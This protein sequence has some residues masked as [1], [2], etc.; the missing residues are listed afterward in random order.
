MLENGRRVVYAAAV[1]QRG[2]ALRAGDGAHLL[3]Q[4]GVPVGG[5]AGLLP[6]AHLFPGAHLHQRLC[7]PAGP[8]HPGGAGCRRPLLSQGDPGDPGGLRGLYHQQ[9]VHRPAHRRGGHDPVFRLRRLPG[10]DEHYGGAVRPEGLPGGV[11]HRRQPGVFGALSPHRLPVL[12]GA[13]HRGLAVP[14]GGGLL[15]PGASRA[16][17]GVAVVPVS[18]PVSDDV[19][20]CAGGL[21]HGRPQGKAPAPRPHRRLPGG[22]GP[23]GGLR[24]VLLVHRPVLPVLPGVWVVGLGDHPAGVALPVRQHPDPGQRVQ[25]RVVPEE[26]GEGPPAE[27]G[28]AK[29]K[30]RAGFAGCS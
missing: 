10:A 25:L 11:A 4:T 12:C 2:G 8:E 20:L 13:P 23:G 27:P 1:E 16:P 14:A 24:P 15:P 7:G 29:L 28:M 30:K 18:A 5:R 19:S 17:L 21:P 6:G 22:G 3:C 9:S 26:K